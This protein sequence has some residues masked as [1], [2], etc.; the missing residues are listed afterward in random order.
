MRIH[1]FKRKILAILLGVLIFQVTVSADVDKLSISQIVQKGNDVYLYVSA[2][3]NAG[4]PTAEPISAEQFSVS[5]D[6]GQALPVQDAGIFQSLNQGVSY[7]FCIDIS[8]SVTEQEMQEI[9]SSITDF[10][11]GMS[12]EDYARVI[13]IGTEITSVC[14]S[15]Q[16]RNALNAAIQG[17]GRTAD[18]TYLYKGISFALDGQRK[19]IDT[20]PERAAV[21]LFTDGMDDSDGA[22]S[23]EQVLVDIAETRIPIYAVGLKG[24]DPSANLNSVGQIARQSGGSVLSYNDM[25]IAE[26]VQTIRDIM[27]NTYQLHVQPEASSFGS[28]NLVWNAAYTSGGYSVSSTNYVY[29]LGLDNV[30]IA[31]PTVEVTPTPEATATPTEA[32][33]P[34]LTPTPTPEP[35][36]TIV[37]KVT[38][39]VQDNMIICIAAGLVIIALIIILVSLLQRNKRK[40]DEFEAEPLP[41]DGETLSPGDF[42]KTLEDLSDDDERTIDELDPFDDEETVDGT[43][44]TGLKLAFE[45]TFDGRTETVERVLRDQL[46]LGRGNECDVDVVLH[47]T[48]EERKQTSR[49]HAFIIDRTDGLYVKDNSKN[50]TY[51]N[52]VEVMGEIAL[53]DEDVLQLGKATVKVKILSY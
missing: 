9:R 37:D 42:D 26:A 41:F 46:I 45:I 18:Y 2:L 4:K 28:Q 47:S 44:D 11:N 17:I 22:S 6:K 40:K 39:F 48:L 27:C 50:K 12:A 32:P 19:S 31:T 43:N 21:I 33:T 20:M 36:K 8:K 10:V 29:S 15:T 25:S 16:D 53:R 7:I 3:D 24:K 1:H 5:I 30:V 23:E 34:T 52:G 49:K 14:D 13:T 51:L 38:D 35:E